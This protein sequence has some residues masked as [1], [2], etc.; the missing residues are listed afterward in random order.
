MPETAEKERDNSESRVIL[1]ADLKRLAREVRRE[2]IRAKRE[3]ETRI[4]RLDE[5]TNQITSLV[6]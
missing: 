2:A 4:E 3:L 5:L 1:A 6:E